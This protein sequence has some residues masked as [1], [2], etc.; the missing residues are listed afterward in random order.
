MSL[1]TYWLRLK[2]IAHV[3][4]Q[5]LGYIKAN[6][7]ENCHFFTSSQTVKMSSLKNILT[8]PLEGN[9]YDGKILII[10]KNDT[11]FFFNLRKL[12]F[13]RYSKFGVFLSMANIH[14]LTENIQAE[15]LKTIEFAN[16]DKQFI[17]IL[18]TKTDGAVN[19]IE[20][21]A[22]VYNNVLKPYFLFILHVDDLNKC[23]LNKNDTEMALS[24]ALVEKISRTML[25]PCCLFG[26]DGHICND[27]NYSGMCA[28]K[29]SFVR[30]MDFY[31]G[32]GDL[33]GN[34]P[35]V[36]PIYDMAKDVEFLNSFYNNIF[37]E[38]EKKK[39]SEFYQKMYYN[40]NYIEHI[41]TTDIYKSIK[42]LIN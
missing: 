2:T 40:A 18:K 20:L 23:N 30:A 11:E 17:R 38:L 35:V 27:K 28:L 34:E 5:N 4:K 41:K 25:L 15:M 13:G 16:D 29:Q 24:L 19:Y 42:F 10:S 6:I 12:E 1:Q 33:A 8:V 14:A 36:F 37:N 32:T 22:D 31:S 9:A 39:R 3:T 21:S 7:F 26:A